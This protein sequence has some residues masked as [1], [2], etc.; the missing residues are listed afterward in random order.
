MR[1]VLSQPAI[2]ER[3]AALGNALRP[4]TVE[5]FRETVKKDRAAWAEVVKSSGASVD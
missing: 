5:Q 4:E 1:E 2:Q 3:M